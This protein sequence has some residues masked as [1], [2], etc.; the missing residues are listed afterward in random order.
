MLDLQANIE[1]RY[2]TLTVKTLGY[3]QAVDTVHPSEMSSD[4][5]FI[6]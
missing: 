4:A 1:R 3:F 5:A 6:D 2:R